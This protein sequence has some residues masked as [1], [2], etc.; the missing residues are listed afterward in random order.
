MLLTFLSLVAWAPLLFFPARSTRLSSLH[1]ISST[2]HTE[3]PVFLS[4][5]SVI[6][7]FLLC[8]HLLP[9]L[10]AVL[11]T[12][13]SGIPP[14]PF[15]PKLSFLFQSV[16]PPGILQAVL[17]RALIISHH[18]WSVIQFPQRLPINERMQVHLSLDVCPGQVWPLCFV[19]YQCWKEAQRLPRRLWGPHPCL[20]VWVICSELIVQPC[21]EQELG[22]ETPWAI[23]Q[24][25]LLP[26]PYLCGRCQKC[27][28][29]EEKTG[30]LSSIKYKHNYRVFCSCSSNST[31][32]GL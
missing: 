3:S 32:L 28:P 12:L 5:T 14:L 30:M 24:A 2:P 22:L 17:L 23:F 25:E 7:G 27:Y 8:F 6:S 26:V 18:P 21:C 10:W 9:C 15:H 29:E 31:S 1:C 4:S 20:Q 13:T 19:F 16:L 11:C